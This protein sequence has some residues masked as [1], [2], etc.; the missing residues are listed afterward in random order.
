MIGWLFL[1]RGEF[2]EPKEGN[3]TSTNFMEVVIC[4]Y[5]YLVKPHPL[6]MWTRPI[7]LLHSCVQML[8]HLLL[9]LLLHLLLLRY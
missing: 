6:L 8:L 4:F 2:V 7:R 5:N 9:L 3:P 1:I